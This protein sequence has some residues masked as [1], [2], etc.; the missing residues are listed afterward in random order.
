MYVHV[1]AYFMDLF[2]TIDAFSAY[3]KCVSLFGCQVQ[4]HV[5]SAMYFDIII[6]IIIGYIIILR[7]V[8]SFL[9]ANWF[10]YL[11]GHL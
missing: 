8:G 3:M 1:W 4:I 7:I 2:S 10:R 11:K 6:S 5:Q 9:T